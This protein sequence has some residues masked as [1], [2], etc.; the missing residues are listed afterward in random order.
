MGSPVKVVMV[1]FVYLVKPFNGEVVKVCSRP[2]TN[3]FLNEVKKV[4][5]KMVLVLDLLDY[6]GRIY[7][8][9]NLA[10]VLIQKTIFVRIVFHH[11]VGDLVSFRGPFFVKS[12]LECLTCS[13]YL[14]KPKK[15]G[16]KI[17]A[18]VFGRF[19]PILG[20]KIKILTFDRKVLQTQFFY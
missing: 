6:I 4:L 8:P 14:S 7:S 11:I 16:L 19:G 1:C 10:N 12:N 15:L 20:P 18:T 5:Y 3:L 2:K 13:L 17:R 9:L